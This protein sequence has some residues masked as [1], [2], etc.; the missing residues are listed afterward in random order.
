MERVLLA[1]RVIGDGAGL[2]IDGN[3][4][5]SAAEAIRFMRAIE[6][7]RVTWLEEPVTSDDLTGLCDVRAA[8]DADVTAGE[9]GFDEMYFQRMCASGAVD[10]LQVDATRCGG[11]TGWLAAAAIAWSHCL[12]VSAHCAPYL[13][14]PLCAATQRARHIE[15]F[16]DHVRI[17]SV[18]FSGSGAARDGHLALNAGPGLGLALDAAQWRKW[19]G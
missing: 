2:F 3:G 13:H 1:R 10:C 16:H 9:Y 11:Y 15:W 5:Y 8:I 4:A 12:D 18:L 7:A 19:T 14:A 17:E 6:P